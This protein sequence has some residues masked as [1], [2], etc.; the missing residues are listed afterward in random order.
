MV[1]A[2]Q[3]SVGEDDDIFYQKRFL[4]NALPECDFRYF[5]NCFAHSIFVNAMQ[6][7]NPQGRSF[8]VWIEPLAIHI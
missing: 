1:K 2:N 4:A 5:S 8:L 3:S 6:T 7:T